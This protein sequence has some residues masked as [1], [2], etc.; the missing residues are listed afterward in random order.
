MNVTRYPSYL[1]TLLQKASPHPVLLKV[2]PS[3][4]WKALE[5]GAAVLFIATLV[6]VHISII[7]LRLWWFV[8]FRKLNVTPLVGCRTNLSIRPVRGPPFINIKHRSPPVPSIGSILGS[9]FVRMIIKM[10]LQQLL[11]VRAL[12]A[13]TCLAAA[14]CRI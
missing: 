6:S 12:M 13:P 4:A 1:L 2:A 10:R 14:P 3:W 5:S 9:R 7:R 8:A 11:G